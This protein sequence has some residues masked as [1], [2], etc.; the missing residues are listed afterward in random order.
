MN[1]LH[2][3][4]F[5]LY[6]C[7]YP[8]PHPFPICLRK[9][10][11]IDLLIYSL[12]SIFLP[13]F[14][15]IPPS[16]HQPPS[17]PPTGSFPLVMVEVVL[18]RRI[19]YHLM[20][21]FLPSGLFVCVSWLTFLVPADQIPGRMVLTITTLLTL[22]SM[23]AGVRWVRCCGQEARRWRWGWGWLQWGIEF[24]F[25]LLLF[26]FSLLLLFS[27]STLLLPLLFC[28]CRIH[29]LVLIVSHYCY[30]L[31]FC[32]Y[33]RFL[34]SLLFFRFCSLSNFVRILIL[35]VRM[36]LI[37]SYFLV[38]CFFLLLTLLFL[39]ILFHVLY[40]SSFLFVRAVFILFVFLFFGAL[41]SFLFNFIYPRPIFL[42]DPPFHFLI[43]FCLLVFIPSCFSYSFFFLFNFFS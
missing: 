12:L 7:I 23:F 38:V 37:F 22:V 35:S 13:F 41:L 24:F 8:V 39:L 42:F 20:N 16:T 32:H 1:I 19:S 29:I 28:F 15:Y 40:C 17:S 2:C 34:I 33:F 18:K 36:L 25:M 6:L 14:P 9:N 10:L 21:T 31:C 27:C 3:I 43:F 26:N 5:Y 30:S 11:F 4:I